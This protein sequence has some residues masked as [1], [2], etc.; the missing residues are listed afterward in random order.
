MRYY[1]LLCEAKVTDAR[2]E[3]S[4]LKHWGSAKYNYIKPSDGFFFTY[5]GGLLVLHSEENAVYSSKVSGVKIPEVWNGLGGKVDLTTKTIT[6]SKESV[7]TTTRQRAITDVKE[8][9]KV[10]K[11]LFQFGVKQDFVVKGTPK[12]IPSTVAKILALKDP[13]DEILNQKPIVM[14]HG[15]SLK[16]WKIIQKEGLRPGYSD[17]NVYLA[18]TEKIAEFYGKR[19]AKK[20]NDSEYVVL[21][22]NVPDPAK[23]ASDDYFTTAFSNG[24]IDLDRVKKRSVSK[25][26][27]TASGR[28]LGQYAYSG[29]ILPTHISVAKVGKI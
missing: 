15:T 21:Q 8:L 7:R 1:Q 3:E 16:N 24:K 6:I 18:T 11:D 4:T 14:Y 13:T 29:I 27:L 23:L 2:H 5:R 10:L 12:H 19:Q 28:E 17:N 20:D 25:Y 26:S 22:I 9:Q